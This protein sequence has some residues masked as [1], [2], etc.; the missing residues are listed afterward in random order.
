MKW[1]A[2]TT[3]D[4]I[5]LA[6]RTANSFK[7]FHPDIPMVTATGE[8]E[9]AIF[10]DE[11]PMDGAYHSRTALLQYRL[12]PHLL[13][14]YDGVIALHSDVVVTDKMFEILEGDFDVAVSLGSILARGGIRYTVGVWATTS[15]GY[16]KTLCEMVYNLNHILDY[17]PVF[18]LENSRYKKKELDPENGRVYYNEDSNPRWRD[19]KIVN[20]QLQIDDKI[21]RALHWCGT[22]KYHNRGDKYSCSWFTQDVKEY[23]NKVTGTTDFTDYDGVWFGNLLAHF[24]EGA[25]HPN[26]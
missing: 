10:H 23:L 2:V 1:V 6:N 20:N 26:E 14:S 17:F 13:K 24:Y 21:V 25:K 11:K 16:A 5:K 19:L 9:M 15:M 3:A 22:A 4:D 7:Y 8:A 18:I 12:V